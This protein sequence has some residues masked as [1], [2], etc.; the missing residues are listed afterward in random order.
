MFHL[1]VIGGPT[2]AGKSAL[3]ERL[4]AQWQ[5]PILSADSR[6]CYKKL[7]I[8]TGKPDASWRA[9][10]PD[11]GFIDSYE[12]QEVADA[13]RFAAYG[14]SILESWSKRYP[15]AFVVGGSG[16]YID[17]LFHG[18]DPGAERNEALREELIQ[19]FR[20]KGIAALHQRLAESGGMFPVDED[21]PQRVMRAIEN[22]EGEP[23]SQRLS[24][25][26]PYPSG[27]FV[28]NPDREI[29]YQQINAR[30]N[31]M[32]Q[33]GWEKEARELL[34]Y[35]NEYALKT[36]GYKEWFEHFDGVRNREETIA[37]IQQKT[38]QYA[39][40][41]ITWFKK[42]HQAQWIQPDDEAA[43][44]AAHLSFNQKKNSF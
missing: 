7:D 37:L 33:A 27:W 40:R 16:L 25:P 17:A 28:V 43:V 5:I 30:V 6:Q 9:Q 42:Y 1:L 38:R 18:F 11:Y 8:G 39:K 12:P 20:E 22:A 3:A 26:L 29:L 41:Q 44:V 36:V 14:R 34:P 35:R 31:A 24:T 4:A 13:G 32:V 10:M 21:N 23:T 19:L 2:G 15:A